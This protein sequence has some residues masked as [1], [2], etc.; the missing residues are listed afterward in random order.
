MSY[1]ITL[2]CIVLYCSVLYSVILYYDI[3]ASIRQCIGRRFL[4]NIM[5]I[6]FKCKASACG[7]LGFA[8]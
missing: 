6:G 8:D 3:D 7:P 1:C 2:Y 4:R 5:K